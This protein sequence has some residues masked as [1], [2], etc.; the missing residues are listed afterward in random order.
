LENNEPAIS[1]L[2]FSILRLLGLLT[3]LAFSL[4]TLFTF[5]DPLVGLAIWLVTN[6]YFT[7]AIMVVI[8]GHGERKAFAIGAIIGLAPAVFSVFMYSIAVS[9]EENF[10][11]NLHE[12][13][14]VFSNGGE[15]LRWYAGSWIL[16]IGTGLQAVVF[17]RL[18]M[19]RE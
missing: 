5:S 1:R 9:W 4:A 14:Q 18:L 10:P 16:S 7:L 17:R 15:H 11:T 19:D 2:Q 3:F 8:Y 6:A 12:W 13:E